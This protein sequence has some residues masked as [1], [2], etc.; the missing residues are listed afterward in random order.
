MKQQH[1]FG[2]TYKPTVLPTKLW[3]LCN[4]TFQLI[5]YF[6]K[7]SSVHD[8]KLSQ[9]IIISVRCSSR[10]TAVQDNKL[11]HACQLAVHM[12]LVI[13]ISF[14]IYFLSPSVL[15]IIIIIM[16]CIAHFIQSYSSKCFNNLIKKTHGWQICWFIFQFP[17]MLYFHLFF[18]YPFQS[19]C[20]LNFF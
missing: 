3:H 18:L 19:F 1:R 16:P 10:V 20:L 8:P 4:T 5:V 11:L 6:R 17:S 14:L 12:T 15:I 2:Y 7:S 13:S 9:Y